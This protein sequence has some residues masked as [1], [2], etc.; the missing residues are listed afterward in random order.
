MPLASMVAVPVVRPDPSRKVLVPLLSVVTVPMVRPLAS[1]MVVEV[2]AD[3]AVIVASVSAALSKLAKSVRS[4]SSKAANKP[5]MISLNVVLAPRVATSILLRLDWAAVT[6][7][8]ALLEVEERL[9][10]LEGRLA[11]ARVV[12]LVTCKC[13]QQQ[14]PYMPS[15]HPHP[16]YLTVCLQ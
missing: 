7:A 3:A 8:D 16:C 2:C 10:H 6:V 13:C 14:F 1:R 11:V 9:R 4:E 12:I 5:R 15:N